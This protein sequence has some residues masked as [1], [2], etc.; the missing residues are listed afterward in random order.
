M[1]LHSFLE[2]VDA[3]WP[4]SPGL[5]Q[6][7]RFRRKPNS[8]RMAAL[9][10]QIPGLSTENVLVL[11]NLAAAALEAGEV[12]IEIGS[13]HG[14]TLVGTALGNPQVSLYACDDF[15]RP[16]S[17]PV[18]LAR[19]VVQFLPGADVNVFAG[20]L[21]EFISVAPWHPRAVG[22]VFYDGP[23]TYRHQLQT[24][25]SIAPHLA[26]RALL[27]IDDANDWPTRAALKDAGRLLPGMRPLLSLHTFGDHDPY[28]WNGVRV[29]QMAGPH[30]AVHAPPSMLGRRLFWDS[31]I[32][33]IQRAIT[34]PYWFPRK[35]T[36]LA[37]SYYR[38]FEASEKR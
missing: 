6:R 34:L 27:V 22:L 36:T 7:A 4:R 30:P 38:R 26:E 1:R 21:K 5:S 13:L 12:A 9:P 28:W 16:D 17:S 23:H 25:L 18:S 3:E 2:A 11:L 15:S 29:Y 10:S 14:L 24:L 31:G 8:R 33:L 35:I 32:G 19:T 37:R 20:D